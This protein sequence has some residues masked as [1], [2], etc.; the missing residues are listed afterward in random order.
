VQTERSLGLCYLENELSGGPL[1]S[2]S[3]YF[4]NSS[5]FTKKDSYA[6][7]NPV[8]LLGSYHSKINYLILLHHLS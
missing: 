2:W 1:S 3:G 4:A 7:D 5:T 6:I 8:D